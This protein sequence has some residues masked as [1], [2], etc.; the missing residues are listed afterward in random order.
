MKTAA[1][2]EP[3]KLANPSSFK[4][5]NETLPPS[6]AGSQMKWTRKFSPHLLVYVKIDP[7]CKGSLHWVNPCDTRRITFGNLAS[8]P[9][10]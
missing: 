1:E 6:P 2:L 9:L 10:S 7:P 4:D 8:V 5:T 3:P